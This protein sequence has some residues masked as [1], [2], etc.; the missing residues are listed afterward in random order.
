MRAKGLF[1]SPSL[2]RRS[3]P[4]SPA[5]APIT[6]HTPPAISASF[7][8]SSARRSPRLGQKRGFSASPS[9]RQPRLLPARTP[10]FGPAP[11]AFC[12]ARARMKPPAGP[13]FA[14]APAPA[15]TPALRVRLFFPRTPAFARAPR[16]PQGLPA[17]KPPRRAPQPP[18]SAASRPKVALPRHSPGA[19]QPDCRGRLSRF[20]VE[21]CAPPGPGPIPG[22][23]G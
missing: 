16:P 8:A 13:G 15:H 7:T 14:W 3:R 4:K 6:L 1:R 21:K 17:A 11:P 10:R 18:V 20:A 12:P 22:H 23:D 5:H 19:G 2:S 9:A